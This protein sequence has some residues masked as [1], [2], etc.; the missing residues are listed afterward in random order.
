MKSSLECFSGIVYS[1]YWR[2][3]L[4]ERCDYAFGFPTKDKPKAE[5]K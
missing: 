5:E 1:E 4:T 3:S 2:I